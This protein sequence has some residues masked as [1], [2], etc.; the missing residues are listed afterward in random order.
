MP[1]AE[2]IAIGTELLLGETLDTNTQFIT[3]AL[4]GIG[5]D[6]FRTSIIGDNKERIASIVREAINRVQ[7]IIT[8]GGLGPTVDDPTR[9]ALS[10][11]CDSELIFQPD[12]WDSIS[13]RFQITGRSPSENQ[14]QQAYIP[15]NAFVIENPVGTAPAFII[16]KE[17]NVII[18]LP[19]VPSEMKTLLVNSV[20]PFL[21]NHFY[22]QETL[23]VRTLHLSGAGEGWIDEK[24][25]DLELLSNPTV[26]L[27]AHYGIVDIRITAKASSSDKA[28]KLIDGIETEIRIRIND[29][30]FGFDTEKLEN[31]AVRAVSRCGWT[32]YCIEAGSEGLLNYCLSKLQTPAYRGGNLIELGK[33]KLNNWVTEIHDE[34]KADVVIGLSIITNDNSNQIDLA[35]I[36]PVNNFEQQVTYSGSPQNAPELGVNL[37]MDRLWRLVKDLDHSKV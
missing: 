11:A 22:L 21:Q 32:V 19:G 12:L 33:N 6:V 9:A 7:I 2:I 8:T 10:L 31:I 23:I 34:K 28:N 29:Y 26:G 3:H 5:V 1:S 14:K 18:S 24:I 27:A 35:I 30:I 20:L 37:L 16:V 13:K 36:T 25:S 4:R 17:E 15:K